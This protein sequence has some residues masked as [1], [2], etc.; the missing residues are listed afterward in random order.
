M[1]GGCLNCRYTDC[2][3]VCS[4]EAFFEGERMLYILPE[5]SSPRDDNDCIKCEACVPECLVQAIRI[6]K[7]DRASDD[8]NRVSM[9]NA[10]LALKSNHIV[11]KK[12]LAQYPE[13]RDPEALAV[14]IT[15]RL[16]LSVQ[17]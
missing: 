7:P 17:R 10:Q 6:V 4:V 1:T 16:N 12:P 11:E 3:V 14:L 13:N 2:V 9:L 5:T 8:N 15:S